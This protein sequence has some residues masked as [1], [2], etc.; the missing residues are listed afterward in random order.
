MG[1]AAEQR[2]FMMVLG[3]Q[4][5]VSKLWGVWSLLAQTSHSLTIFVHS[6]L[7][8]TSPRDDIPNMVISDTLPD[9]STFTPTHLLFRMF[10]S[11]NQSEE[12]L[13][14]G[15]VLNSGWNEGAGP[16]SIIKQKRIISKQN[17][18]IA[19]L[20][21]SEIEEMELGIRKCFLSSSFSLWWHTAAFTFKQLTHHC[22]CECILPKT[23]TWRC[24][25]VPAGRM[26]RWQPGLI[27]GQTGTGRH[28][29]IHP[30]KTHN[31]CCTYACPLSCFVLCLC[32]GESVSLKLMGDYHTHH[33]LSQS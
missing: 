19:T 23:P 10:A 25:T 18:C 13:F 4:Q 28:R 7:C 12:S 16:R 15:L 8:M 20:V 11:G 2:W 3:T 32:V 33:L 31:T 24:C 29:C 1:P 17:S 14:K 27:L 5:C 21:Q 9:L 22:C 26:S 30:N 6:W